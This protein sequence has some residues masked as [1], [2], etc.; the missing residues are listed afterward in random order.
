MGLACPYC[1]RVLVQVLLTTTPF[2]AIIRI[3]FFDLLYKIHA[4]ARIWMLLEKNTFDPFPTYLC[5]RQLQPSVWPKVMRT[6]QDFLTICRC[7]QL[8]LQIIFMHFKRLNG[9]G[10]EFEHFH[11]WITPLVVIIRTR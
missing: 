10:L 1:A 6:I 11:I 5:N 9:H 7:I 2:S 3:V 8:P 4:G